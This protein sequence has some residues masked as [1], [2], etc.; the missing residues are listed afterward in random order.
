MFQDMRRRAWR[1][2]QGAER[3]RTAA[4]GRRRAIT[5]ALELLEGRRLLSFY[6]GPSAIRPVHSS[7]GDF[8]IQ[9][10][11]PGLV[12]V[13]PA[14]HG[15]IDLI[16]FGTTADSTITVTLVHPRWHFAARLLP[17]DKLTVTSGLLGTLDAIPAELTGKM[18]PL[19][20]T[21][22]DL[23]LGE[24][25]PGAQ[26]D[27]NGSVGVMTVAAIDLGPTGHVVV[28]GALNTADLTDSMTIGGMNIDGGRFTI[29]TDSLAP[30][31]ILGSL[32]INHDGVFSIGRDLDGSLSVSGDLVLDSGGQ[33]AV[34]R[35]LSD[36][37]V[38][39]NLIVNPS[40]S[41]IVV[42]G[43][44]GAV[45]VDGIFQGQGGMAAP[46]LFDLGVGLNISG[47]TILGG[48]SSLNGL[49]NANI[50]AGGSISGVDIVYGTVNSTIQP[51][52]PPPAT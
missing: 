5:P 26:V 47:L 23:T 17:I 21:V 42:G 33:L 31:S 46:T 48:N 30:I 39:G 4:R 41:G 45:T 37:T 13:H 24:I 22:A 12:K 6:T 16:A 9:V 52:T 38:T 20:N 36:L 51:N 50:R 18:T 40:G 8:L 27:I 29:G 1:P 43:E 10:G 3:F 49:I 44:L 14:G 11:G 19:N 32:T 25:G 15:A 34:G 28:S 35:N 2:S 7:A